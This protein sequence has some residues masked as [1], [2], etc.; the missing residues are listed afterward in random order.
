MSTFCSS[1]WVAKLC[2][3]VC[4]RSRSRPPHLDRLRRVCGTEHR[5]P[6]PCCQSPATRSRSGRLWARGE[7]RPGATATGSRQDHGRR[8]GAQIKATP[9]AEGGA[10]PC[11]YGDKERY[12][13]PWRISSAPPAARAKRWTSSPSCSA[14]SWSSS[15]PN[16]RLRNV[17]IGHGFS[18]SVGF[19]GKLCCRS[20]LP[21]CP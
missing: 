4:G 13:S 18:L 9:I 14:S 17:L 6:D 11:C 1:R 20:I 5:D 15:T 10:G 16:E 7:G 12:N 2:C 21:S 3:N 19:S 8:S